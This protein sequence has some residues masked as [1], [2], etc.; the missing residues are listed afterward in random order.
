MGSP[1]RLRTGVR[2]PEV[3]DLSFP[4]QIAHRARYVFNRHVRVDAMLIE[5]IDR[6]NAQPL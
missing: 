5:K 2:Q 3:L 4:N 6:F 1:N